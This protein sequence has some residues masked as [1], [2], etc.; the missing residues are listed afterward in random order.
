M[1]R[2][3]LLLAARVAAT[4]SL[5]REPSDKTSMKATISQYDSAGADVSTTSTKEF[6]H[7]QGQ[8]IPYRIVKLNE[9]LKAARS[10]GMGAF[11]TGSALFTTAGALLVFY[12]LGYLWGRRSILPL[13]RAP[14]TQAEV[15]QMN[16]DFQL[17]QEKIA[18]ARELQEEKRV[19]RLEKDKERE[20]RSRAALEASVAA[21]EEKRRL[22]A[23]AKERGY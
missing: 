23:L 4:S 21:A 10:L 16:K 3:T 2:C 6:I 9:E 15:E 7:L 17:Q 22:K 14:P 12:I 13:Q 8:L 5:L 11:P 1:Q 20:E 19:A 18:K